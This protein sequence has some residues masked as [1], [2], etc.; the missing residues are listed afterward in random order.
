MC[1][2][3]VSGSGTDLHSARRWVLTGGQ[4]LKQQLVKCANSFQGETG[5]F[6]CPHAPS[7][8]SPVDQLR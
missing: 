2:P 5:Q 1:P 7:T 3:A 8:P 4:A 6:A